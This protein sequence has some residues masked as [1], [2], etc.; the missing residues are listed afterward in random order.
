MPVYEG[1]KSVA[2]NFVKR[3]GIYPIA[4][5]YFLGEWD[6]FN[7]HIES[8]DIYKDEKLWIAIRSLGHTST[9]YMECNEEVSC[10]INSF[11]FEI[12]MPQELVLQVRSNCY[13]DPI[14]SIFPLRLSLDSESIIKL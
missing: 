5:G 3:M 13:E 6:L 2:Y 14:K 10:L 1:L 4:K 8:N 12:P 7:E 9:G 11:G